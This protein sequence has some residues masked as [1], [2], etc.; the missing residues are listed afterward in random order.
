MQQRE[1]STARQGTQEKSIQPLEYLL[2]LCQ[3]D[4]HFMEHISVYPKEPKE[5]LP[6]RTTQ[7]DI[8]REREEMESDH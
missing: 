7:R 1:R 8:E 3:E 4:S 2:L 6:T 5:M